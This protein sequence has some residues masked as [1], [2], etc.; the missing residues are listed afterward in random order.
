MVRAGQGVMTGT[1]LGLVGYS[2]RAQFA[3][4]HLSVRRNGVVVDP[5]LG[6]S[7]QGVCQAQQSALTNSLWAPEIQAA[8]AYSD[9]AVIEAGFAGAPV[10]PEAAEAGPTLPPEANSEALVFYIR[11]INLRAGD[12]MRLVVTG[13]GDF[14]A[15]QSIPPLER[16]KAH[17]VAFVGK[18]RRGDRWPPGQYAGKAEILRG[19]KVIA[20]PEALLKIP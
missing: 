8:L 15:S 11:L 10:T 2:G 4:A 5:F 17:Y 3:H 12:A 6:M 1:Q 13:P 18:K 19:G 9:A 20:G 16:E 7:A 14:E